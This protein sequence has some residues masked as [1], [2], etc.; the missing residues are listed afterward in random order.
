M[1]E[2]WATVMMRQVICIKYEGE[3]GLYIDMCITAQYRTKIRVYW[4]LD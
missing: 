3:V 4:I 2:M 1:I